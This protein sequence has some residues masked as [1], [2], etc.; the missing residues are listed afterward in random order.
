MKVP[1]PVRRADQGNGP[2]E[3][4]TPRPGPTPTYGPYWRT[5]CST[6]ASTARVVSSGNEHRRAQTLLCLVRPTRSSDTPPAPDSS[7]S[8]APQPETGDHGQATR[9]P[10]LDAPNNQPTAEARTTKDPKTIP[11]DSR[12]AQ[13]QGPRRVGPGLLSSRGPSQRRGAG[14]GAD[15][16]SQAARR[17]ELLH[18]A[19]QASTINKL[20]G[21]S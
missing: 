19:R 21:T 7:T 14:G 10:G 15:Q 17:V 20:I 8:T 5:T 18:R 4:P 6:R 13:A 11:T 9:T 3:T 16:A 2:A 12:H 1:R